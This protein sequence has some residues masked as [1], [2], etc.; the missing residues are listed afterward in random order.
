MLTGPAA[1]AASPAGAIAGSLTGATAGA[2]AGTFLA[3][4]L[5]DDGGFSGDKYRPKTRD[6]NRHDRKMVDAVCREKGISDR[7]G[8]GD[9]IEQAKNDS[10]R[11]P[12]DNFSYGELL[13]LA[14]EF[15]ES[16]GE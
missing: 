16:G 9:Y 4:M 7:S 15:F 11:G 14:D 1:V 10:F 6:A 3:N 13:D 12:S 2:L 5:D 8:F